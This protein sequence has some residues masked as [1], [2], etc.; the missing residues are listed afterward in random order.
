MHDN[1]LEK[2]CNIFFS[3]HWGSSGELL[4]LF[5]DNRGQPPLV[6]LIFDDLQEFKWYNLRAFLTS[7]VI[8]PFRLNT[9]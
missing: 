6:D 3:V 7:N 2:L 8:R 5:T 1:R 4:N 9:R